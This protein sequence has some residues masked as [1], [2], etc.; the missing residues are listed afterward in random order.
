MGDPQIQR[1][2]ATG[3][4]MERHLSV[5]GRRHCPS[6]IT[7]P[8]AHHQTLE[9]TTF[10]PQSRIVPFLSVTGGT[11][12][13]LGNSRRIT[14]ALV[15]VYMRA[16]VLQSSCCPAMRCHEPG[17]PDW[18]TKT[19]VGHTNIHAV[20]PVGA[21]FEGAAAMGPLYCGYSAESSVEWTPL[22]SRHILTNA[23]LN[24]AANSA[25]QAQGDHV[26]AGLAACSARGGDFGEKAGL[27][28]RVGVLPVTTR[29]P[30]RAPITIEPRREFQRRL[31]RNKWD[32]WALY[33]PRAVPRGPG[34]RLAGGSTDGY[35][36]AP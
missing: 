17:H 19:A 4:T 16:S 33:L 27:R 22:R 11:F 5:S 13:V 31:S 24:I 6:G 3:A 35:A 7:T 1:R 14:A 21:Y 15:C 2:R 29:V 10:H 18:G 23:S 8:R 32:F 12:R 9:M 28:R 30:A 25:I 36:V 20:A 34:F 26:R